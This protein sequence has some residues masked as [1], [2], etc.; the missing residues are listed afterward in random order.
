MQAQFNKINDA[1]QKAMEA[2]Q[3]LSEINFSLVSTLAQQQMDAVSA[4][5]ESGTKHLKSL[6]E[7][8]DMPGLLSVNTK[9]AEDM[10]KK[11]VSNASV[12]MDLL[13]D[14][15]AQWGSWAEKN[16]ETAR[17]LGRAAN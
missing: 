13:S 15:K 3:Q 10:T 16:L 7:V 11:A 1:S 6:S 17:G 4:Y 12:A 9:L 14:A 8:K 2:M 5:L